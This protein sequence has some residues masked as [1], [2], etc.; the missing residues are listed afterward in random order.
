MGR[1][2]E[3]TLRS[4][5]GLDQTGELQ[6]LVIDEL[7]KKEVNLFR[8]FQQGSYKGL[9]LTKG[10]EVEGKC[11]RYMY[12]LGPPTAACLWRR[13]PSKPLQSGVF[14]REIMQ[15]C[16]LTNDVFPV[17]MGLN[18]DKDRAESRGQE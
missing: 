2:A 8:N 11:C 12:F 9:E 14:A 3:I 6:I 5:R 1:Y 15:P 4:L 18:V 13:G 7:E 16:Q 17:Q 10:G